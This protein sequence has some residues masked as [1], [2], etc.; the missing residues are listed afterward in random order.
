MFHVWQMDNARWQVDAFT[1]APPSARM[2][3]LRA[4]SFDTRQEAEAYRRQMVEAW[5]EARDVAPPAS[6]PVETGA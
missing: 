6:P 1:S 3:A 2:M 5:A 4:P